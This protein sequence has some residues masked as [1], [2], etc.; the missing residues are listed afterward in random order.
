L[1]TTDDHD[2]IMVIMRDLDG[3]T[4]PTNYSNIRDCL[5]QKERELLG[6]FKG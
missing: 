3:C 4:Y 2:G 5:S 6:E 1:K